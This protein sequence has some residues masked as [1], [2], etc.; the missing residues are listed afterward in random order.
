MSS[1]TM[2]RY[3]GLTNRSSENYF[4]DLAAIAETNVSFHRHLDDK[5]CEQATLS[6]QELMRNVGRN[7]RNVSLAQALPASPLH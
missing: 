5:I 4:F 2:Q 1:I 3:I 6:H 7:V